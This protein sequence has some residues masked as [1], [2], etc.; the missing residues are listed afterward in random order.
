MTASAGLLHRNPLPTL[1]GEE[2]NPQGGIRA[3]NHRL[4]HLLF[5]LTKV[6][7]SQGR[8]GENKNSMG[9]VSLKNQCFEIV[10]VFKLRLLQ[11]G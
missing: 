7:E 1:D 8:E 9:F 10:I 2:N 6:K 3:S 4:N 5:K 11:M